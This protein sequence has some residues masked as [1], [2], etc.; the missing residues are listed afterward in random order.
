MSN[1]KTFKQQVEDLQEEVRQLGDDF[2]EST[3]K[4]TAVRL[5]GLNYSPPVITPIHTFLTM[6]NRD[7]LAEI[8]RILTMPDTEACALAPDNTRQCEDLRV[9][10]ITVLVFYY[11]KL[12]ELRKGN[13]E[14]WDEVDELYVHD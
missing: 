11:K 5:K 7:L 3:L 12:L 9:Q 10:F 8:D 13:P 6:R 4:E 2:D 14:E 1:K